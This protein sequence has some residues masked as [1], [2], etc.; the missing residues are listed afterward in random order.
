[1]SPSFASSSR[2]PAVRS[3]TVSRRTLRSVAISS[4]FFLWGG[5]SSILTER[6]ET[7]MVSPERSGTS[8]CEAFI[9]RRRK[10]TTG[11][12]VLRNSRNSLRTLRCS[13]VPRLSQTR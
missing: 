10:S 8:L 4:S 2:T 12:R 5:L 9:T 13:A 7:L 3:E 11:R 6:S 1:M